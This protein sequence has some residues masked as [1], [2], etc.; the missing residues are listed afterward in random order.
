MA[1]KENPTKRIMPLSL[2]EEER[3]LIIE[4][5]LFSCEELENQLRCA[6]IQEDQ[7]VI[8]VT[9]DELDDLNGYIAAEANH[10][11]NRNK[12]KKLDA[13]LDK[14]QELL[15]SFES[16]LEPSQKPPQPALPL[17]LQNTMNQVESMV[18][19]GQICNLSD[20]EP[21]L[22][23]IIL[24]FNKQVE[25]RMNG[26]S[27]QQIFN[28]I[29]CNWENP[30]SPLHIDS[31]LP[32][33]DILDPPFLHNVRV[34]LTEI[35]NQGG[36]IK[37]T[38]TG[39]LNRAFVEKII[40]SCIIDPIYNLYRKNELD[41]FPIHVIRVVCEKA[42]LI[43]KNKNTFKITPKGL[44]LVPKEKIGELYSLLFKTFFNDFNI[45]YPRRGK[46]TKALQTAIAFTFF[47]ISIHFKN[48]MKIED[49]AAFITL[50]GVQQKMENYDGLVSLVKIR[51]FD[52]LIQF[53]LIENRELPKEENQY[54]AK[55]EYRKTLLY[56]K[57]LKFTF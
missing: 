19:S 45:D 42:K 11:K 2:L 35:I 54:F 20:L 30:Q 55:L 5:Q 4:D 57:F 44:K 46:E 40:P 24:G 8:L 50:P 33:K 48:W 49:K 43:R 29:H 34:F 9:Y 21:F 47:M 28:L 12:Q 39:N 56:D 27:M 16:G 26:L 3:R 17:F 52:Q 18:K 37:T 1:K 32:E 22:S 10:C 53:G 31:T 15:E 36:N 23:K 38:D 25:D 6:V 41:V 14:T 13:I 51:I 7:V